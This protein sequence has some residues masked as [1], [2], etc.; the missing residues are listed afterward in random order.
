MRVYINI[1]ICTYTYIYIYYKDIL[2]DVFVYTHILLFFDRPCVT[3]FT[4][5]NYTSDR[6]MSALREAQQLLLLTPRIQYILEHS[7]TLSPTWNFPN[8]AIK[9]ALTKARP[10]D[11]VPDAKLQT[12]ADTLTK[13]LD[14]IFRHWSQSIS[15]TRKW[16]PTH[17]RSKFSTDEKTTADAAVTPTPQQPTPAAAA[18]STGD[19]S[20]SAGDIRTYTKWVPVGDGNPYM[21]SAPAHATEAT[22]ETISVSDS[23][24]T[25][26]AEAP[27]TPPPNIA[28][29]QPTQ[30]TPTPPLNTVHPLATSAGEP[31]TQATHAPPPNI[32]QT[33]ASSANEPLLPA[34]ATQAPP[35]NTVH[36]SA[37]SASKPPQTALVPQCVIV[38][39]TPPPP[40]QTAIPPPTPSTATEATTPTPEKRVAHNLDAQKRK[41]VGMAKDRYKGDTNTYKD[42]LSDGVL[43][44]GL[45]DSDD[46]DFQLAV[47]HSLQKKPKPTDIEYDHGYSSE[48]CMAFRWPY[49]K[50][51]NKDVSAEY[52]DKIIIMTNK[53]DFEL[54]TAVWSD[55][56][57]WDVPY[58][59]CEDWRRMERGEKAVTVSRAR[60]NQTGQGLTRKLEAYG[61]TLY[62]G[63]RDGVA[64]R[65]KHAPQKDRTP[66]A[67]VLEKD[68]KTTKKGWR[69]LT[70]VAEDAAGT[71]ERALQLANRLATAYCN[72]EFDEDS[73]GTHK[74]NYLKELTA[75]LANKA[76]DDESCGGDADGA[77]ECEE[78]RHESEVH[79]EDD[80]E[81]DEDGEDVS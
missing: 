42:M 34:Q 57:T 10:K 7:Y 31:P 56:Y 22:H 73:I 4:F 30:V 58:L 81:E 78:E 77:D 47:H 39:H 18:S 75:D 80:E 26:G 5:L 71:M 3:E 12:W 37:D 28:P 40:R 79:D 51:L 61:V 72:K 6:N 21:D 9:D 60:T 13:R 16:I 66:L 2:S 35:P 65:V 43:P 63:D 52:A 41:V 49:G 29:P 69:T 64:V 76:V 70:S 19:S 14:A 48:H 50:E 38:Q 53:E 27:L 44:D 36:P 45:S 15:K 24:Q 23:Q 74:N 11:I 8:S 46:P 55:G 59:T 54:P 1:C 25:Q 17:V 67:L 62:E 33:H 68:D 32:V 20:G